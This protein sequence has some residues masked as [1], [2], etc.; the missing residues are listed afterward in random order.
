M[1]QNAA[2]SPGGFEQVPNRHRPIVIESYC[3]ACG[4]FVGA[5]SE[6][7]MLLTAEAAHRCSDTPR[8]LRVPTRQGY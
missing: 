8:L 3:R 5:S 1:A 7:Y 4:I 2:P 6:P